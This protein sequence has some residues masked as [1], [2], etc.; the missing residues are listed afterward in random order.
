MTELFSQFKSVLRK[1]KPIK[2]GCVRLL[3][4]VVHFTRSLAS[5]RRLVNIR[6]GLGNSNGVELKKKKKKEIVSSFISFCGFFNCPN[7]QI[8]FVIIF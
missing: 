4:K 3:V 2:E 6:L 8:S 7:F 1:P 5:L